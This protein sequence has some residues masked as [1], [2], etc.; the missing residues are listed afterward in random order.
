M[1]LSPLDFFTESISGFVPIAVKNFKKV[2]ACASKL[3]HSFYFH[4]FCVSNVSVGTVGV[5][6]LERRPNNLTYLKVSP[7]S[8]T[9]CHPS[10]VIFYCNTLLNLNKISYGGLIITFDFVEFNTKRGLRLPIS[11]SSSSQ[12]LMSHWWAKNSYRKPR[13][14]GEYRRLANGI[15]KWLWILKKLQN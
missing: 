3:I 8:S 15:L 9:S 6:I 4:H 5:A 2:I 11:E 1:S 7:S 13:A 14:I 10:N 12:P